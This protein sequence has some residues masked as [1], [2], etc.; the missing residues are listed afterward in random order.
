MGICGSGVLL[1]LRL[2]VPQRFL[3]VPPCACHSRPGPGLLSLYTTRGSEAPSRGP[4]LPNSRAT[5][6][7]L[8]LRRSSP[9]SVMSPWSRLLQLVLRISWISICRARRLL[10]LV[11]ISQISICRARRLL[12]LVLI[13]QISIRRARSP[14]GDWA[15]LLK[16]RHQVLLPVR[17]LLLQAPKGPW[18]LCHRGGM[19]LVMA[20]RV[21]V[22]LVPSTGGRAPGEPCSVAPSR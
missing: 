16:T 22:L 3:W 13:S 14:D 11:L 12:L 17:R 18:W 15:R 6:P 9:S 20:R 4:S 5:V 7:R 1:L 19:D 8:G 10:L 21:M 2:P